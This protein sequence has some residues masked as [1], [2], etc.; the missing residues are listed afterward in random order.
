MNQKTDAC[1]KQKEI[2]WII[3]SL[4]GL[5]LILTDDTAAQYFGTGN[6]LLEIILFILSTPLIFHKCFSKNYSKWLNAY[7]YIAI[8]YSLPFFLTFMYL[9][10][11]NYK[12]WGLLLAAAS[13]V[14]AQHVTFKKLWFIIFL[15]CSIAI[16]MS[17]MYLYDRGL[18]EDTLIVFLCCLGIILYFSHFSNSVTRAYEKKIYLIENVVMT[19]AH[20]LR[21]PIV[22]IKAGSLGIENIL[23]L[24]M[25]AYEKALTANLVTAIDSNHL[26]ALKKVIKNI[27]YTCLQANMSIDIFLKNISEPQKITTALCSAKDLILQSLE[28]Y[29]FTEIDKKKVHHDLIQ[30]FQFMGDDNLMK[31]VFFNLLKNALFH[32]R[33]PINHTISIQLSKKD[34]F[35]KITVKDTGT[36]IDPQNLPYIF[37][38]LFSCNNQKGTGLGLHYCKNC[39]EQF[40]G[41]IECK[42]EQNQYSEFSIYLPKALI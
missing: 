14:I 6:V 29:P 8:T 15:G 36:G 41:K 26:N 42:S 18:P 21:T 17:K 38:R 11:P 2:L 13:A 3:L 30:D 37:D 22:S 10:N 20:E 24:L 34:H 31:Y 5:G 9:N 35:G 27:S 28:E 40:G 33:C 19:I 4:I 16:L 7:S 1:I 23:P 25:D 32:S 12:I 39:V